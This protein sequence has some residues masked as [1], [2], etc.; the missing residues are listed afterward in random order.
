MADSEHG[1]GKTWTPVLSILALVAGVSAVITPMYA[2]LINAESEN[3]KVS[4]RVKELEDAKSAVQAQLAAMQV[5]FAEIETQFRGAKDQLAAVDGKIELRLGSLDK[6]LQQEIKNVSDI[7]TRVDNTQQI[8]IRNV[9]DLQVRQTAVETYLKF[10]RN[11]LAKL[12]G[13]EV[14]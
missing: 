9:Q 1:N 11:P 7:S 8:N 10:G 4:V 12:P 14:P 5:Q 13:S 3:D 6:T 2:G